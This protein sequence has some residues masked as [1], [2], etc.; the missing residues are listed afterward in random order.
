MKTTA[1][2]LVAATLVACGGAAPPVATSGSA[3]T[4]TGASAPA[5]ASCTSA[6]DVSDAG[7]APPAGWKLVGHVRTHL[8]GG[9]PVRVEARDAGD[10]VLATH[11]L[12]AT[13][14]YKH[15]FPKALCEAGGFLLTANP[16]S[17]KESELKDGAL[18]ADVWAPEKEDE[19]T[20]L[21][22]LCGPAGDPPSPKLMSNIAGAHMRTRRLTSKRWRGWVATMERRYDEATD[23]AARNAAARA[24]GAKLAEGAKAAGLP[25]CAYADALKS[26]K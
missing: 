18:I 23:D 16:A 11:D 2:S 13:D 12:T 26:F 21:E 19:K 25:S 22:V 15:A 8:K 17:P 14:P 4:S 20:D 5:A 1:L 24:D 6:Y 7:K 3:G 10:K 9:N